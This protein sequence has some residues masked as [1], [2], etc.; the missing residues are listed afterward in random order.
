MNLRRTVLLIIFSVTIISTRCAGQDSIKIA[1]SDFQTFVD[2]QIRLKHCQYNDSVCESQ[3]NDLKNQNY[4]QVEVNKSTSEQL[5]A[6]KQ[7]H[8]TDR[9]DLVNTQKD[10][11]KQERNNVITKFIAGTIIIAEGIL[12]GWFAVHR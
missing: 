9:E 12:F 1:T 4:Y 11:Y 5:V 2:D 6:E 3:I 7:L 10:L 8:K